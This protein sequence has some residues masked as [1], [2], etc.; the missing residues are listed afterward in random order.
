VLTCKRLK[1]SV[2]RLAEGRGDS[3][4]ETTIPRNPT[5]DVSVV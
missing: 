5:Q 3:E 2:I 4:A 1:Q